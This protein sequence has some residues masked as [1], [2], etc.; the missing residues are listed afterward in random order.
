MKW[1]N[2]RNKIEF[3]VPHHVALVVFAELTLTE[4]SPTEAEVDVGEER[5]QEGVLGRQRTQQVILC[6]PDGLAELAVT[7]LD[8]YSHRDKRQ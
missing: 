2:G 7:G 4:S 8:L 3:V 6:E 1:K 5:R